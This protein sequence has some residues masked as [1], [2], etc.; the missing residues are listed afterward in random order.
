MIFEEIVDQ[1]IEMV[2]RRGRVTYRMLKR[3]FDLDDVS[4]ED[5]K[6]EILY[7]Q[8]QI[9]DDEGRGFAW[10]G[11]TEPAASPPMSV[12]TPATDQKPSPISYTPPYLTEKILTSRSALEGE[13]KRV[14]V[15]FADLRGSM[16]L[17]AD[18]DPERSQ[19]AARPGSGAHDGGCASL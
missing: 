7:S 14:T 18:R 19:A 2:R 17:L 4:L 6:D 9:V 5:L 10:T 3:Q 16:E 11:G 15:L 1:A 8:S 13:R 12:L